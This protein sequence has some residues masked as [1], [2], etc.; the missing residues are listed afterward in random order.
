MS[1]PLSQSAAVACRRVPVDDPALSDHPRMF[2]LQ[3]QDDAMA[4]RHIVAGDILI[5]EHGLEPGSGDVVAAYVDGESVV[6]SYV[7]Q[8]GRPFLKA[9]HAD[10]PDLIP[11]QELV[12]Q[13]TMIKLIRERR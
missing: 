3:V 4:G 6:R 13:G 9:A 10:H 2:A 11:A 1:R 7:L 5:F 8:R 12:I